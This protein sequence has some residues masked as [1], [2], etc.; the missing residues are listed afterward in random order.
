MPAAKRRAGPCPHVHSIGDNKHYT[1]RDAAAKLLKAQVGNA[2]GARLAHSRARLAAPPAHRAPV[3]QEDRDE[4]RAADEA[5]CCLACDAAAASPAGLRAAHRG[6][7]LPEGHELALD[8]S[9]AALACA[10]CDDYVYSAALEGE[11]AAAAAQPKLARRAGGAGGEGAAEGA[12]EADAAAPLAVTV[13]PPPP[14]APAAAAAAPRLAPAALAPAGAAD[15]LPPGLLGLNNLGNTC[16][17]NAVLQALLRAPPLA[18]HHLGARHVRARC[19]VAAAGGVCVACELDAVFSAAYAGPRTPHSPAAFLHAWW[20]LAGGA[21]VGYKQQD[22]HEFFLFVLEMLAAGD[23]IDNGTDGSANSPAGAAA[24]AFGGA[25]RSDVVCAACGHASTTTDAFTHLSLDIPPPTRLVAPP[26]IPRA[27]A[28]GGKAAAAA[29]AAAA[30]AAA[31]AAAPAPAPAPA[32]NDGAGGTAAAAAAAAKAGKHLVGAARVSHMRRLQR[33]AAARG[34][35]P[36]PSPEPSAGE[37]ASPAP[38]A[39]PPDPSPSRSGAESSP[40][41]AASD[42][43]GAAPS[44]SR[45][46][47]ASQPPAA[48]LPPGVPLLGHPALAGYHRWP[49]AS[50][51]GCL[52]RFTRAEPLAPGARRPCERC[53]AQAGA[54]KQLSLLRLPPVLALHAKRFEHGGSARATAKKLDT[55]LSFPL[56]GLDLAPFLSSAVLARRHGVPAAEA[57]A[58]PGAAV[59]GTAAAAPAPDGAPRSA[60]HARSAPRRTRSAA[61][62]GAPGASPAATASTRS[63]GRAGAARGAA[64]CAAPAS[65]EPPA[66]PAVPAPA[67]PIAPPAPR[68]LYDLFAVVC[69][70][71]T[72]AGGHY[73]AYVRAGPRAS[74]WFLCDDALVARAPAAAVRDCQAYMLFYARRGG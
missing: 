26:I 25:L 14:G 3:A 53:G 7:R 6:R 44:A 12:T 64:A 72:F 21:L 49:G 4:P 71:G 38:R 55:F 13:A 16:F 54:A 61:S 22:A 32:G 37:G 30:T 40:S 18:A 68:D 35:P 48:A 39:S 74:S 41:A 2:A 66:T 1:L 31:A 27:A 59:P 51:V 9:L 46:P 70:R 15:G 63:A 73:V 24:A 43:G 52:R 56:D 29:A 10:A 69:H 50:L 5:F 33:E 47:A 36:G 60:G 19:A 8:R 57:E 11:A 28:G 42:G 20:Q 23:G 62:G 65:S 34:S 45:P 58:A 17:M 67:P